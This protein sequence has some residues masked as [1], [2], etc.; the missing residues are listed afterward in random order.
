MR[1]PEKH[2]QH[3]SHARTLDS[4]LCPKEHR[5]GIHSPFLIDVWQAK[6][7]PRIESLCRKNDA[8]DVR[9]NENQWQGRSKMALWS[10]I[11]GE[12]PQCEL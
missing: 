7:F 9:K 5:Q 1:G 8:T 4:M 2:L 3:V 6:I 12:R 10:L 11:I